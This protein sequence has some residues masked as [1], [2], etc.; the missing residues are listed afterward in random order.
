VIETVLGAIP[1]EQLGV[2]SM[3]EHLLSDSSTLLRPAREPLPADARVTMANLGFLRW[4]Y[5]ALRD[6]LVLDDPDLAAHEL[7]H[8]A[9]VG[10]H[11]VVETT[12][13]GMGPRH[14]ELPAIARAAG[15]NVVAAYGSYLG[16]S[17]PDW[18]RA[19]TE[20]QLETHLHAALTV[21]VPGTDYR[22]AILGLIG[23][24]EV[25][26]TMELRALAASARAAARS[27]A[28]ISIRLDPAAR[29][30]HR[31]LDIVTDA[32][33]AADRVVFCNVDEFLDPG[34]LGELAARG[35][36]LEFDF[37]NEAYYHDAYKDPT[38]AER[39]AFLLP[40]LD[41]TR[42]SVVFGNSVWSKGQLRRFGGMGYG[43][44]LGRIVPVLRRAGVSETRLHDI[45][46]ERPRRL[47]T[48]HRPATAPA[49]G[50]R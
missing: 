19:L 20:E 47:L 49:G 37:G 25:L 11:T 40:M 9:E 21:A 3:N 32:G 36:T 1:P 5:L 35:A 6:N 16:R 29:L 17:L 13:W 43:H 22:A 10:L 12:S 41:D 44:L 27:G 33:L 30:G 28:S 31:V 42:T 48:H 15:L 38:D 8:A 39:I 14:T 26:D 23:T 24:S 46:V 45:L 7:V 4:N 50:V 34:Y 18:L 2:T